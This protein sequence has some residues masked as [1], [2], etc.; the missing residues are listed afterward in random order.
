MWL[1]LAVPSD[2]YPSPS[3]FPSPRARNRN[4]RNRARHLQLRKSP[5]AAQPRRQV[6]VV[7]QKTV[8]Q[9]LT[10]RYEPAGFRTWK[11][12]DAGIR[13][14]AGFDAGIRTWATLHAGNITASWIHLPGEFHF[15]R[16]I[17]LILRKSRYPPCKT[18]WNRLDEDRNTILR[19]MWYTRYRPFFYA[20]RVNYPPISY[21]HNF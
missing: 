3:P 19:N 11:G 1:G 10:S 21:N 7:E 15:L 13:T 2:L 18:R 17:Q 16:K 6:I 14:W 8:Q 12:F 9:L 20:V 5:P 4:C